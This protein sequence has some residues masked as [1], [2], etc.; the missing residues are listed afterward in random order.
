MKDFPIAQI[1]V[2][3]RF[4]KDLGNIQELA[5]SIQDVGLLHPIVIDAKGNLI[6]GYRR[7]KAVGKL[8]W[9]KIDCTV[10]DIDDNHIGEIQENTQRKDFTASEIAAIAEYVEKTR[11]GHRPKK[12]S[13]SDTLPRGPTNDLVAKI[14]NVSH[15]TVAKI[16]EINKAAKLHPKKFGKILERVDSKKMSV[17]TAHKLI[18][19]KERNLPKA[20][21][22]EGKFDV[23]LCDVPIEYDD[24]GGRGAAENHY[25]TMGPASLMRMQIPSGKNAIIFFW[26]SPSIMYSTI[27]LEYS[28]VNDHQVET[29]M[30][31]PM[32]IYKAILDAW[33]FELVKGEFAWDKEIIGRGNWNRNQHEN[34]L[35]AIKGKMP[36]PAELYPS[37]I[38]ERRTKQHSKK[39]ESIYSMIEKMYPRR[40]YLELFGRQTRKGW[41]TFG[42]QIKK[43]KEL[44]VA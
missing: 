14:T 40:K 23:I 39:P 18:T 6:A 41:A 44:V 34:C 37:L 42:N 22:P 12:G 35:I 10:I 29:K 26:M 36:T 43:S 13:E 30:R 5:D 4:R 7:I 20:K 2:G 8:G 21:M 38:K 31:L 19:R 15:D 28:G 11:I 17:D 27:D 25:D 3:K 16:K 33:G 24:K 1:S 9:R 32:P